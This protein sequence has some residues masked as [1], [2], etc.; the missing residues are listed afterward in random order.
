MLRKFAA[1]HEHFHR[2]RGAGREIRKN[3]AEIEQQIDEQPEPRPG[4]RAELAAENRLAA[5]QRVAADLDV[6][7]RLKQDADGGQPHQRA[8]VF[9]GDGRAQQPFAAADGRGAHHDSRTDHRQDISPADARHID[10]LARCSSAAWP[11]SRGA[12]RRSGS[13]RCGES[14]QWLARAWR[15]G[16]DGETEGT[17]DRDSMPREDST[18]NRL[19]GGACIALRQMA[20]RP[21]LDIQFL[22]P[23][24]LRHSVASSA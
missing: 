2:N 9:G 23:P 19:L 22:K 1:Q 20:A 3:D 18:N 5:V 10:Q 24:R 6:V 13:R 16:S 15:R 17:R 21:I 11:A 8:A 12:E 4:Q 14:S 7:D